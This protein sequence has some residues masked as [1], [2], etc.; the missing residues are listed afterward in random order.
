MTA[1]ILIA[2]LFR[3]TYTHGWQWNSYNIIPNQHMSKNML[4]ITISRSSTTKF[5]TA[6]SLDDT[7]HL[8]SCISFSEIHNWKFLA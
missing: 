6:C 8:G 4:L 2:K 3:D 1:L 5:P 7:M